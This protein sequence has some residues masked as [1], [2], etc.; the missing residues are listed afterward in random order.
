[1]SN[2]VIE[3]NGLTVV[4][5]KQR[6]IQNVN[7]KVNAGEVF[8]FLGPNGAGKTTMLRVLL[9]VIRPNR[10]TATIFGHDCQSDGVAARQYVG[11]IPGELALPPN[12]RGRTYL[13]MMDGIRSKKGD[14]DY[15]REL[16]ARFDLDISRR[17]REYS[18]GNKQKLALVAAFMH[19]PPLLMLDEPTIGLDP[20]IQQAVLDT[21]REAKHE[22][23]TVFFSSHILPEVQAVCDRVGI[24]RY[25]E[26]IAIESVHDLLTQRFRRL[27]IETRQP[28]AQELLA[29]EGVRIL[30]HD[31]NR[32]SLE[33]TQ[34]LDLLM[35]R[36]APYSI[37]DVQTHDVSLEEVFLAF[38]HKNK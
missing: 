22:G 15:R 26:L 9:D 33:I 23:R 5:G 6:G 3:T 19:R 2:A 34:N 25:G 4:Y 12:M 38:Y 1:M 28:I 18:R 20:L 13:N 31:G 36:L 29:M 14:A 37:V 21:V 11:Y 27:A 8:G 7:L 24:I 16:C 17:I 10:G 35:Q 32:Y 30:S